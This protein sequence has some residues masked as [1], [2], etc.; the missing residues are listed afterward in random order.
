MEWGSVHYLSQYYD[1]ASDISSATDVTVTAG[2]T[3]PNIDASLVL[4]GNITGT[5]T[6]AAHTGLDDITVMV[7]PSGSYDWVD[8]ATTDSDGSYRINGLATGSYVV[9]FGDFSSAQAFQ[10]F[11]NKTTYESANVVS[12]SAG[13]TTSGIDAQILTAG[14][15]TG[16]VTL[17]GGDPGFVQVVA[18]D[19]LGNSITQCFTGSEEGYADGSYDLIGLPSG[20]YRVLFNFDGA[21]M[22]YYNNK[23][24]LA[25]ADPIVVTA[26]QT[27][28]G[29]DCR[30]RRLR[31]GSSAD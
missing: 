15:I 24:S 5:V 12:V 28:S 9:E 2:S 1:G 13:Q 3:T 8:Q 4:G 30:G 17:D 11:N 25:A 18:Y 29:I 21:I 22:K 31:L 14:H 16:T 26:G 7:Y 10:Y 6:G 27:T 19:A 20:S 23:D